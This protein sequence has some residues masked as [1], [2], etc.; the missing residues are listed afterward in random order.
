MVFDFLDEL[1]I[2]SPPFIDLLYHQI[3][4]FVDFSFNGQLLIMSTLLTELLRLNL[5]HLTDLGFLLLKHG[6]QRLDF[7][8]MTYQL[9]LMIFSSSFL[10]LDQHIVIRSCIL[11][12]AIEGHIISLEFAVDVFPVVYLLTKM[13]DFLLQ[14]ITFR[15]RIPEAIAHRPLLMPEF[16]HRIISPLEIAVNVINLRT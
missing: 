15:L 10:V 11:D 3:I 7:I 4:N 1:I 16:I 2:L 12:L 6:L 14:T 13:F 5:I 8:L 9:I